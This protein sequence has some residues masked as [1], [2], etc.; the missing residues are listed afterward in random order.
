LRI[1]RDIYSSHKHRLGEG[2]MIESGKNA[3]PEAP[4]G[5]DFSGEAGT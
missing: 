1:A 2:A 3:E 5:N 4:T